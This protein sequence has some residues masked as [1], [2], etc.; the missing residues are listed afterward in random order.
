MAW[1]KEADEKWCGQPD[2]MFGSW[3]A[4]M[5]A[6]L[7]D[8]PGQTPTSDEEQPFDRPIQPFACNWPS[9]AERLMTLD[10]TPLGQAWLNAVGLL[11]TPEMGMTFRPE[12]PPLLPP[13]PARRVQRLRDQRSRVSSLPPALRTLVTGQL[14]AEAK[15]KRPPSRT[16]RETSAPQGETP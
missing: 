13:E 4:V 8:A 15:A 9:M 7:F 1:L 12:N 16:Q 6:Q 14:A 5:T 11:C 10:E 2:A 3:V